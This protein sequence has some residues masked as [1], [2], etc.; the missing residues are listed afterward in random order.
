MT[1]AI[2]IEATTEHVANGVLL[3]VSR[4]RRNSKIDPRRGRNA[5]DYAQ[6][7]ESVRANGVL[8]AICVRPIK[9]EDQDHDY[10]IVFGNTRHSAAND[11]GLEFVPAVIKDMTDAQARMLAAIENLQ[12]ADLTPVDEARH[13]MQLLADLAN[14]H[15]AVMKELGWSRTKLDSR[16]LL[17]HACDAV[18]D[19]LIQGQIKI[20]HAE[21]LCRLPD[22][23]QPAVLDAV[24]SK[25]YS[26]ADTRDR[27]LALTRDLSTARFNT[28]ECRSCLHNSG[29]NADLFDVSLG[30]SRCQ[31]AT[32]WNEKTSSLIEVKLI[33][34]KQDFGVAHTDLTLPKDGYTKLVARGVE[35]IGE[36]QMSACT[37][38]DSYGAVVS[39][40]AGRE[41]DVIGGYCFNRTCLTSKREEYQ[42]LVAAASAQ[43]NVVQLPVAGAT[44]PTDS[45]VPGTQVEMSANPSKTSQ[46]VTNTK[47]IKPEQIRKSIRRHAFEVYSRAARTAVLDD[48]CLALAV[49]I[50]SMYFD[51]RSDLTIEQREALDSKVGAKPS[52]IKDDR[53]KLEIEL[54]KKGQE[55][56]MTLMSDVAS[57]TVLRNDPGDRFDKSVS[58]SQSVAFMEHSTL[59]PTDYFLMNE[60]Y[61]KAQV[62]AGIVEDCAKSGFALKYNEV[63]GDKA[64]QKLSAG[65][66]SDLIEGILQFTDFSWKGYLPAALKLSAQGGKAINENDTSKI[67]QEQN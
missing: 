11:A 64:F 41:G 10:E 37:S 67:E 20:G 1:S 15:E 9:D 28:D 59:D 57:L 47:Q 12:R 32:C 53:A 63:K 26:V 55:A 24:I 25:N 30:S 2:K 23:D 38:C 39:T 33:E 61:L 56:L 14:D 27:L 43:T 29:A 22:T 34:A 62:K 49:A 54:A 19:A 44:Q 21:L 17:S 66:T 4:I 18:A 46:P 31:N 42:A 35:G 58:G 60:S 36:D 48:Q 40:T 13:V 65:K 52:L 51:L 50:T 3:P 7:V 16:I 6:F 5:Q 45:P 8:Q